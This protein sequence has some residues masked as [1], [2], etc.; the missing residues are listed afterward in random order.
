VVLDAIRQHAEAA[1]PSKPCGPKG[2]LVQELGR[3]K[4]FDRV[5]ISIIH[6][7]A[8]IS[9]WSTFGCSAPATCSQGAEGIAS[10]QRNSLAK[11]GSL[12]GSL[13]PG[14]IATQ[15]VTETLQQVAII[16]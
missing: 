3:Q 10:G 15:R 9:A 5:R 4:P 12:H 14:W 6:S 2:S 16:L 1:L 11:A 13:W 8:Q 7:G